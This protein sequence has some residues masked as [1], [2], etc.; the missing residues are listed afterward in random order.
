MEAIAEFER[1]ERKRRYEAAL[2]DHKLLQLVVVPYLDTAAV[3]LLYARDR[4][5]DAS[6]KFGQWEEAY[7]QGVDENRVR[8]LN[9]VPDRRNCLR[10]EVVDLG[11]HWNPK[12]GFIPSEIRGPNSATFAVI[13]AAAQ[14][15]AWVRQMD[16][17][18]VPFALAGG[19]EL[20]VPG[21]DGWAF[22]PSVW[23]DRDYGAAG[24]NG[25]LCDY[26]Y[27]EHAL[28]ILWE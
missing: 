2:A 17:A 15:P 24:L 10:I 3:T 1:S 28:P 13:Y 19:L 7:A 6:G 26:R 8:L 21:Y 9:G 23:F 16:G 4:Y 18:N 14:N 12:D 25:G 5:R 20:N 22:L 11:A 27:H